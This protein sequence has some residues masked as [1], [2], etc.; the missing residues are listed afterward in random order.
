MEWIQHVLV[1]SG[2]YDD[3]RGKP[4]AL[5]EPELIDAEGYVVNVPTA[6]QRALVKQVCVCVCVCVCVLC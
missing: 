6:K 3:L 5:Q 2:I 1:F 4:C